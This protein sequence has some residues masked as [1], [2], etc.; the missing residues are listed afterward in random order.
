M[1]KK[2][3]LSGKKGAGKFA[4]VDDDMFDVL[5]EYS[6]YLH[7]GYAK[8]GNKEIGVFGCA[9]MHRIINKTPDGYHTDHKN[10]NRLDNRSSNLR[11]VTPRQNSMNTGPSDG[12]SSSYKG[13]YWVSDKCLWSSSITAFGKTYRLGYFR[14]EQE[15]AKAYDN[16]AVRFFGEYACINNIRNIDEN[17]QKRYLKRDGTSIY[18]GVIAKDNGYVVYCG[19]QD[20]LDYIGYFKDELFAAMVYDAAVIARFDRVTASQK[21]NFL[22]SLDDPLDLNKRYVFQVEAKGKYP[23]VGIAAH[24]K[25]WIGRIGLGGN[26]IHKVFPT[27]VE[28]AEFYDKMILCHKN[29]I[30][31]YLNFPENTEN[32]AKEIGEKI[33][34]PVEVCT[35]LPTEKHLFPPD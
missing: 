15:A 10:R 22:Q 9:A 35:F 21:V 25:R 1:V 18:T 19:E 20:S 26:R 14:T 16:N 30:A 34:S 32:Y 8:G 4:L 2:I 17:Y 6:W 13:V 28:A 33:L 24:R 29:N 5:I 7:N 12:K 23:Y 11:T 27:D 3:P 31:I